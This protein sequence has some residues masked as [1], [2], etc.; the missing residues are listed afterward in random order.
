MRRP[1]L[2]IWL[3]WF[4][5]VLSADA[6][7][8]RVLKVLPHFVDLQ[9][10]HTLSPSLFERDAYQAYLRQHTT[11]IS[12]I[13]FD[14]HWKVKG[15]SFGPLR[16]RVEVRGAASE[17]LPSKA[18]LESAITSSRFSRWT[19]LPLTGEDYVRFGQI[20]AWRATLWEGDQLLAEHKS[21]L[22]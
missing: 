7:T 16:L 13:R 14:V 5:A 4:A 9:G 20:T 10:R 18:I 6:A 1:V 8:G 21:F 22:W 17:N 19:F 2:L 15:D 11:N 3:L 12:G